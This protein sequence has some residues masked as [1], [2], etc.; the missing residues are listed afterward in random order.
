M[1]TKASVTEKDLKRKIK[2]Q[3]KASDMFTKN[4]QLRFVLS[5]SSIFI[6]YH[7]YFFL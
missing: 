7:C 6:K 5:I 2:R 3:M 4:E 1:K